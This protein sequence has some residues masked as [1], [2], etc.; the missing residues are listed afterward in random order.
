MIQRGITLLT[1]PMKFEVGLF[2]YR[3]H[4]ISSSICPLIDPLGFYTS[5]W[6]ELI[7]QFFKAEDVH[8]HCMHIVSIVFSATDFSMHCLC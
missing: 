8:V 1:L 6:C 3:N 5:F 4:L 7:H 2:S